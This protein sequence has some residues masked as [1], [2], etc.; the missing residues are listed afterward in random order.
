MGSVNHVCK[1][2]TNRF[3]DYWRPIKRDVKES[4]LLI[5][6]RKYIGFAVLSESRRSIRGF[7]L[8]S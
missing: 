8:V 5:A 3:Y 1:V 2:Q 4:G 6:D 7:F